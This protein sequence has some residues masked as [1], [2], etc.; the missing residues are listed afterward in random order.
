MT[1]Q[2]E[3]TVMSFPCLVPGLQVGNSHPAIGHE[4]DSLLRSPLSTSLQGG[5]KKQ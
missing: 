1:G 5:R 3:V 4:V 2:A